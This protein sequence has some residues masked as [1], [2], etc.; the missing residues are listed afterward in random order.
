[1]GPIRAG[2]NQQPQILELSNVS[3]YYLLLK[4]NATMTVLQFANERGFHCTR[5]SA[6]P[7][8]NFRM[9]RTSER[10]QKDKPLSPIPQDAS[11]QG[12]AT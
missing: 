4:S 7:G 1:V 5:G 2:T 3:P 10:H 8:E 6:K 9:H 12:G 11:Y